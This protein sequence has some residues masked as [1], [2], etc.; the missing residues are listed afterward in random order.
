MKTKKI[1]L[2]VLAL[3]LVAVVSV[4]GTLAY[5]QDQSGPVTNT[6]VVGKVDIDLLE[7]DYVPEDNALT[8]DLISGHTNADYKL[9]PGRVSPK[10]PTVKVLTGS[11]D[12][13]VFVAVKE[14]NNT[15]GEG[16]V[17]QWSAAADWTKLSST[18]EIDG[19]ACDVYAYS[20]AQSASAE[21]P[22]LA[23]GTDGQITINSELTDDL[24]GNEPQLV[25]YAYGVQAEGFS[26]A[27]AAWEATFGA[28]A[29]TNP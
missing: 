22:F 9:V 26:T 24:T 11:E 28:P 13:W 6:F 17:V 12:C 25:F 20:T 4:V 16:K 8:G 5:L 3:A 1:L 19:V 15:L 29:S 7:K 14:V 18:I 2:G 23:G 10:D 27:A 21:L